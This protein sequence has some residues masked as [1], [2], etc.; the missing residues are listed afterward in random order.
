[1]GNAPSTA[2]SSPLAEAK[3]EAPKD[4]LDRDQRAGAGFD[5]RGALGE[6]YAQHE[7]L[8]AAKG[9]KGPADVLASYSGLESMIGTEKIPLPGKDAGPEAWEVV[10]KKL[11]RPEKPEGYAL[12]R[13]ADLAVYSDDFAQKFR[14]AAHKSGLSARQA[15]ALHDW[16]VQEAGQGL[17]AEGEQGQLAEG[18]LQ[19]KLEIAWGSQRDEKL[20][21]ARRAAR[22]F[23]LGEAQLAKLEALTGDFRLIEALSGIGGLLGEDR[24]VGRQTSMLTQEAARGELRRL[25]GDPEFRRAYIDRGHPGHDEAVRRMTELAERANPFAVARA[26]R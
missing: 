9:W 1:M 18:E 13:P 23:G 17:K 11:G 22:H 5:W 8:L 14:Q 25:E 7:K 16:W 21:S 10:W 12:Q 2:E 26:G 4:G 3:G 24:L 15:A 19:R 20:E 6:G